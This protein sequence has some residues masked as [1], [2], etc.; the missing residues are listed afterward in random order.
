[1]AEGSLRA[2]PAAPALE[3]GGFGPYQVQR[4][5]ARG[6][7][8]V[9]YEVVHSGSGERFALKTLLVGAGDDPDEIARFRRE[10]AA[11]GR[12]DHV[13]VARVFAADV[14]GR[15]PYL[16]QEL[17]TGGTLQEHA[18]RSS[19]ESGEAARLVQ[20]L[21]LGLAHSHAAGILHRDL[22]PE[23]VLFDAEGTPK[24]VDFGLAFS[25]EA[26]QRLTA[27][28][29]LLGT[30]AYMAPEQALGLRE[31]DVRV[32]VYGLGGVLY[33]LLCGRAPFAGG[34]FQ[35]IEQVVNAPPER[36]S[37][38]NPAVTPGL[39]AI[40]LKAL[41]K[42]PDERFA[43][44]ASFG[45]ALAE[46]ARGAAAPARGKGRLALASVT[47]VALGLGLGFAAALPGEASPDGSPR[48][49]AEVSAPG[50]VPAASPAAS[51]DASPR[52]SVPEAASGLGR[53]VESWAPGAGALSQE[54]FDLAL[55]T[56]EVATLERKGSDASRRS[57]AELHS[58]RP[59]VVRVWS[60]EDGRE[61][62]SLE[63]AGKRPL[64]LERSRD[65][66]L[67]A[68]ACESAVAIYET[69]GWSRLKF[70]K[71]PKPGP[72]KSLAFSP[73]GKSLALGAGAGGDKDSV[74]VWDV[75]TGVRQDLPFSGGPLAFAD[76]ATLV[77]S[78][79]DNRNDWQLVFWSLPGERELE[80]GPLAPGSAP[81]DM[82]VD[83]Q[84]SRLF[85]GSWNKTVSVW[86]LEARRHLKTVDV[87]LEVTR[88]A[89]GPREESL[90]VTTGR[91]ELIHMDPVSLEFRVA[92]RYLGRSA[93][94]AVL[95]ERGEI[96]VTGTDYRLR[97]LD[98]ALAP[99][100]KGREDAGPLRT[101]ARDEK[102]VLVADDRRMRYLDARLGHLAVLGPAD[103]GLPG[104]L[105]LARVSRGGARVWSVGGFAVRL[106]GLEEV[107]PRPLG[108]KW[109]SGKIYALALAPG[110]EEALAAIQTPKGLR[111]TRIRRGS[112]EGSPPP[113]EEARL[114]EPPLFAREGWVINKQPVIHVGAKGLGVSGD[115]R[116]RLQTWDLEALEP[117]LSIGPG[118]VESRIVSLASAGGLVL[119]G[120]R[121]GRI[122]RWRPGAEE[123][124]P[125]RGH[126]G[127]VFDLCVL[128]G[129]RMASVG[130]D[131]ELVIWDLE[132][133]WQ[134]D[135]RLITVGVPHLLH[136]SRGSLLVATTSGHVQAYAF[137]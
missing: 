87:G 133:G 92:G 20:A 32:D 111:L 76:E 11:M 97:R 42:E 25:A 91:R 19:L 44:M 71:R 113:L 22:K 122:R 54:G 104:V 79:T 53:V 57:A 35:I 84:G 48:V 43:D 94:D 73:G 131:G 8:G 58:L 46:E 105:A 18:L 132:R 12:L 81:M 56:D 125:L 128:P 66:A 62:R 83:R 34:L 36:P 30:P 121:D 41:A 14:F 88:V 10:A 38:I 2:L 24:L 45:A 67:V 9:V 50:L 118:P 74:R 29:A 16:A 49:T 86:D 28:G 85:L 127:P 107:T 61:L 78:A 33:F 70:L 37:S 69:Q 120:T 119:A 116:G 72:V 3:A 4:E 5:V 80:R 65:R 96:L 130:E 77:V 59:G 108:A 68:V 75:E 31:L 102:G 106:L 82:E 137:R 115:W 39:E 55:I 17:L 126:K 93:R 100:W 63:L 117:G 99:L 51:P 95:L 98:Q 135:R 23:N 101:L 136:Y 1:V 7:M 89:L 64:K 123:L 110:G 40:C 90:L 114:K 109:V 129:R 112:G 103:L 13:N 124:S 60:L 47:L 134:L 21:A 26:S 15:T 52:A 27:T 6:G